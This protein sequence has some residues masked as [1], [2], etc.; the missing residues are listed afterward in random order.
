MASPSADLKEQLASKTSAIESLELEMSNLRNQLAIS[1]SDKSSYDATIK[2]LETKVSALEK[3]SASA[4]E[5]LATLKKSMAE[6]SNPDKTDTSSAHER[7]ITLLESDLRSA[8]TSAETASQRASGLESK[9]ETLTKLSRESATTTA[10]RD[11]E[12]KDLKTRLEQFQT[13]RKDAAGEDIED[14]EDEERERL[15]ARIRDLEAETFE[16]RRGVWRDK[17]QAMQPGMDGDEAPGYEDVDLNGTR[18]PSNTQHSTFQNVLQS[19]INAFTGKPTSNARPLG[20]DR[21]ES[22]GLLSDDDDFDVDAYRQA[23]EEEGKRRIERMKEVK[24]GLEKWRGWRMDLVDL[25]A[26]GLGGSVQVGP[27]FEV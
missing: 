18:R 4:S 23:Q 7:K 9:I 17:R 14:L 15:Q 5:E 6:T 24:R 25:R 20:H 22:L 11:K 13:H 12:I 2:S 27:I 10:S 1:E 21:K 3:T 16:L 26:G 8:Q 19:G